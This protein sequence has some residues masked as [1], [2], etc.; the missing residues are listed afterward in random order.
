MASRVAH[1]VESRKATG[2]WEDD[3]VK[4]RLVAGVIAVD[5]IAKWNE[6]IAK[7]GPATA[8]PKAN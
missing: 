2:S 1:G 4:L 3:V 6:V 5:E 7:A 8:G